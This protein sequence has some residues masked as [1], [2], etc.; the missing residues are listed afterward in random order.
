VPALLFGETLLQRLHQF[1]EPAERLDLFLF[2]FGEEFV[3]Q[4]LQPLGRDLGLQPRLAHEFEALEGV[5]ENAVEL[6]EVALV[7]HQ[8]R[9]GQVIEI[10]HPARGEVGIHRLHQRQIF[11]QRHGHAGGFEIVEEIDEH[12]LTLAGP[13]RR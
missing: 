4:L 8:R 10:L 11:A 6:V 3:G 2:F 13:K 9:A 5:A 7:L 12:P 1:V